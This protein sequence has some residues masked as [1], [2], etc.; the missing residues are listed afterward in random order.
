M[1]CDKYGKLKPSVS[2]ESFLCIWSCLC[3]VGVSTWILDWLCAW[4]YISVYSSGCLSI[5]QSVHTVIVTHQLTVPLCVCK[6]L[7]VL[8]AV[9]VDIIKVVMIS[10]WLMQHIYDF[11]CIMKE[12][13]D[14]WTVCP[15]VILFFFISIFVSIM[16]RKI[17]V[18]EFLYLL[19]K[20]YDCVIISALHLRHL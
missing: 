11:M 19:K 2:F 20:D 6:D 14:K 12:F 3:N 18:S 8:W 1:N 17:P 16:P 5:V 13:W 7:P 10:T 9:H 15:C 4:V